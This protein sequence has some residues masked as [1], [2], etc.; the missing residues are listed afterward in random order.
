VNQLSVDTKTGEMDTDDNIK[1]VGRFVVSLLGSSSK[2]QLFILS[3]K[4]EYKVA[5]REF[6]GYSTG[7]IMDANS[8]IAKARELGMLATGSALHKYQLVGTS[9]G[10]DTIGDIEDIFRTESTKGLDAAALRFLVVDEARKRV[11]KAIRDRNQEKVV[12]LT[13]T[14][15]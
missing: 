9:Y 7:A 12:A 8:T 3:G 6:K 1:N 5:M 4:A 11:M 2:Q 14:K 15:G 10:W 13:P